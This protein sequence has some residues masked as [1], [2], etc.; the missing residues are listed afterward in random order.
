MSYTKQTWAN[1]DIITAAKL[2]HMEDGIAGVD[3]DVSSLNT[4]LLA[5]MPHDTASGSIASFH[6]GAAMPVR[7]LSVDIEPAQAGSGDPAPDNVRPISGWTEAKVTRTGKNKLNPIFRQGSAINI[8]DSNRITVQNGILVSAGQ[9]YT[10][11]ADNYTDFGFVLNSSASNDLPIQGDYS[12]C[13]TA[14]QWK[15]ESITFTAT[16]DGYVFVVVKH[17]Q[18]PL[19]IVP[20]DVATVKMQFE[21]GTSTAYEPYQGQTYTIDLDGTRYGGTLDVTSGTMTVDRVITTALNSLSWEYRTGEYAYSYFASSLDDKKTGSIKMLCSQYKTATGGRTT[22]TSDCMISPY[23]ISNSKGI[24]IRDDAYSDATTFANSLAGVQLV[25]ELATPIEVDLTPTEISTLL[26]TNNIFADC[27][28]TTVD[29]YADTTL[30]VNKKIAA[31][32][33]ALS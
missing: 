21:V 16:N 33:A 10:F 1:G 2:N 30:F 9:T 24:C 18:A 32:V 22:L 12:Y 15:N 31:A 25:Y 4:R 28:D 23:N 3:A 19:A 7:D 13:G 27:G 26:G 20:S 11:S 8:T 29:Y 14:T 6:D 5:S 17:M